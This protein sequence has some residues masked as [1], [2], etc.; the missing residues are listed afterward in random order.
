MGAGPIQHQNA[1]RGMKRA[2]GKGAGAMPAHVPDAAFV[3]GPAVP[4]G[5]LRDVQEA[6]KWFG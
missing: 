3:H 6:E 5:V 4:D 1:V 2:A